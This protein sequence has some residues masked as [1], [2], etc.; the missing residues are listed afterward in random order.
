MRSRIRHH[1]RRSWRLRRAGQS[2]LEMALVMV[3]LIPLFIGSVDLGRAFFAYDLLAHAV[4]EGA[5][6][7]SVD[8]NS[9]NVVAGVRAAAGTLQLQ[10][11]DVVVT[12]YGGAT[13]TTK[14]CATMVLG[15]SVR[16]AA[17]TSFVPATPWLSRLLP[18]G[19]ITLAAVA[20]RTYQ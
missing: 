1:A 8:T 9:A 17:S 5:R 13:T 2:T 15:D 19:T 18:G 12:C 6:R 11:S 14:T 4:N 20:Q 3:V 16:V 10:A 7:G